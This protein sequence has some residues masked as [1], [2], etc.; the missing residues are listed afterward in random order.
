[1]YPS[2]L[3]H[4]KFFPCRGLSESGGKRDI[5]RAIGRRFAVLMSIP[6]TNRSLPRVGDRI[7]SLEASM[8]T[9]HA[10]SVLYLTP[11]LADKPVD[12][13]DQ[14]RDCLQEGLDVI[15]VCSV[16]V[17]RRAARLA[18]AT[19]CRDGEFPNRR[20]AVV[21]PSVTEFVD[22]LP[23]TVVGNL[24]MFETEDQAINWLGLDGPVDSDRST[25]VWPMAV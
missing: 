15:V 7:P 16:P 25:V 9:I 1:V 12:L 14:V 17:C 5:V 23:Q 21:T 4:R 24:A 3:P 20:L 10:V 2:R 19:A 18:L 22:S 6:D 8:T 11:A 13:R